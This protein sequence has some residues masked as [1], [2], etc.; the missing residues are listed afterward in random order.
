MVFVWEHIMSDVTEFNV[1]TQEEII[2]K[3]TKDEKAGINAMKEEFL[4]SGLIS[5]INNSVKNSAIEKLKQL[6]LTLD[7]AKTI[8]G[9]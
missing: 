1:E 9:L 5:P 3:F 8:V 7:E 6:G 2:R 4:N